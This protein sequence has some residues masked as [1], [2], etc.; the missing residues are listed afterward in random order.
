MPAHSDDERD[1]LLVTSAEN[2]PSTSKQALQELR[3]LG[4]YAAPI[5]VTQFLS[6]SVILTTV[7]SVGHLGKIEL[8][9]AA[10]GILTFK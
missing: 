7:A 3:M 8:S 10:L 4:K 6:T 9:S 2:A 5:C 1:T